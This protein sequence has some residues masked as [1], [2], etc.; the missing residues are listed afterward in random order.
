MARY[1]CET[2]KN[3]IDNPDPQQPMGT[4]HRYPPQI[5]RPGE[6]AFAPVERTEHCGEYA[7]EI[8]AHE[9]GH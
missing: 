5:V 9:S 7:Y 1:T 3:F 8:T 6:W 4:C 2:C